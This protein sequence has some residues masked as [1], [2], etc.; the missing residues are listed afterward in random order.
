MGV[1]DGGDAVEGVFADGEG[2]I[3]R[4]FNGGAVA[5]KIDLIQCDRC[6][7][8]DGGLHGGLAFAFHADDFDVGPV[9]FQPSGNTRRHSAAADLEVGDIEGAVAGKDDFVGERALSRHDEEVVVGVDIN[10]LGGRLV[11]ACGLHGVVVAVAGEVDG[12]V[13]HAVSEDGVLLHLRGR[14]GHVNTCADAE[15]FC[16]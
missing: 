3:A 14:A 15:F 5:E 11:L 12:N 1:G 13:F 8:V 7:C 4:A 2:E 10:G 6:I 16:G 9:G